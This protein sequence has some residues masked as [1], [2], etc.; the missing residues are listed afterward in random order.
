MVG[1]GVLR[2]GWTSASGMSRRGRGGE[3]SIARRGVGG[4]VGAH[5]KQGLCSGNGDNVRGADL[6]GLGRI[7][8]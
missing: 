1:A 2:G 6:E 8:V 7:F 4:G 3:S 5:Q